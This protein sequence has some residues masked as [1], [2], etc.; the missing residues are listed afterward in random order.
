MSISLGVQLLNH[1][2][3]L[4]STIK[5]NEAMNFIMGKYN[6]EFMVNIY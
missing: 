2:I 5:I 3:R 4:D 1:A 6:D